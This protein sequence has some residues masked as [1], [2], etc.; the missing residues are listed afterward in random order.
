MVEKRRPYFPN[1][2]D[3]DDLIRDFG[4]TKSNAERP[5][6]SSETCWMKACKSQRNLHSTFSNFFS[7]QDGLC[8]C[9]NVAGLF[10]AI[11][12][13]VS[14]VNGGLFIVSSFRSR[15]ASQRKQLPVSPYGPLC[16]SQRRI[17]QC[18]DVAECLEV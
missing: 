7:R 13:T 12:I 2:K 15:A 10:E 3:I 8:F 14:R 18:Q 1:Q 16:A 5:G 17:H 4:L 6:S 11:A 9:N